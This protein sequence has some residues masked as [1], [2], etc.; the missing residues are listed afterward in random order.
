MTKKLG[1]CCI[2]AGTKKVVNILMLNLLSPTP[3]HG[4][5]CVVCG[6]PADGAVAVVC[7]AC[8]EECG[9][10]GDVIKDRLRWVCTGYPASEGRTPI[11]EA[12]G[13]FDHDR[14]GH[15]ELSNGELP[16]L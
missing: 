2:C 1:S 11:Q 3:G 12:T 7:D 5:G 16:A 14:A 15:P 13:F 8:V 9:E 10:N 4:W 6:V